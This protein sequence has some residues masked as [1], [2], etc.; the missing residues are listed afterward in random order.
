MQGAGPFCSPDSQDLFPAPAGAR[1]RP[2][3]GPGPDTQPNADIPTGEFDPLP[4]A[5]V[6][7][8]SPRSRSGGTLSAT[9]GPDAPRTGGLRSGETP[10]SA[11]LEEWTEWLRG[12]LGTPSTFREERGG[13]A[14]GP[15]GG[16]H[17]EAARDSPPRGPPPPRPQPP[18]LA[19][20]HPA[21]TARGRA[22][23]LSRGPGRPTPSL[24]PAPGAARAPLLGLAAP[25][26]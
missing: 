17:R 5:P 24:A 26:W 19:P 12:P 15:R 16:A 20:G 23:P 4:P 25:P 11:T 6:N 22:P 14:G 13:A 7:Q 9:T 2:P 3:P 18:G 21:P 10:R 1:T 8:P